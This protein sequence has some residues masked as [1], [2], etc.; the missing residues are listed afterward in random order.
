MVL[1]LSFGRS[2]GADDPDDI[3]GRFGKRDNE[4][5]VRRTAADDDLAKFVE[6]VILVRKNP[7]QRIGKDK[8]ASE[9]LTPCFLGLARSWRSFH[10]NAVGMNAWLQHTRPGITSPMFSS[11]IMV[12]ACWSEPLTGIA[13]QRPTNH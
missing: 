12:G 11:L 3:G 7:S 5:P 2:S 13:L 6:G 9:K 4:Q 1:L 8:A 10:S